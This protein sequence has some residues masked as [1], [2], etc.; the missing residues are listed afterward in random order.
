MKRLLT[1]IL[2]VGSISATAVQ[3]KS[4]HAVMGEDQGICNLNT[5]RY[6]LLEESKNNRLL[7]L[8]HLDKGQKRATKEL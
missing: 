5:D 6:K 4:E 2:L 7:M 1:L 8:K 3:M